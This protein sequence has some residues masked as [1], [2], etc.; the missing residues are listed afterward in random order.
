MR[1]NI[2]W[3][4]DLRLLYI[5][6]VFMYGLIVKFTI[7]NSLLF[8]V[9]TYIPEV[10]LLFIALL[11]AKCNGWKMR[12]C[13][14][15]LLTF[16][17]LIVT[18]NIA[19]HGLTEQGIYAIRDIYIPLTAFSCMMI[20][21][22]DNE[23][24]IYTKR[25]VKFF[26]VYLIAGLILAVAEQVKGWQ[27]TSVFY[28]G[29]TFYGQD[30]LSKIKVAHNFGLLRAPSL[31]GNFATFGYY[32][33]IAVITIIAYEKSP[34]RR[35]FWNVIAIAC[36]VL[37]TNKSA[38]VIYTIILVSRW[39]VDLRHQTIRKNNAT[40]LGI[41]CVLCI[42]ALCFWLFL[43]ETKGV[44]LS[45]YERVYYWVENLSEV[46]FAELILPYNQFAY[47]SGAEG[48]LS[49]WDNTYLYGLFTQG[50][51]G[52]ILWI[53][54]LKECYTLRT[55]NGD[56]SEREQIFELTAALAILSLTANVTQG[57]GFLTPYIVLIGTG[58]TSIKEEN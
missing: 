55:K 58:W 5:A 38:I 46:S 7:S 29:Y 54:A 26:K 20:P 37:A 36:M 53:N 13:F 27:W 3:S 34:R 56:L 17:M 22:T 51:V 31:S 6:Y 16:S 30:P 19:R 8:K 57:R 35:M 11:G 39:I 9:K 50:I 33:I 2:R 45:L 47:G 12:R 32:S 23:N 10:L 14:V 44:F 18:V 28:T 43:S 42:L 48:G 41:I 24:E 52:M 49:F 1:K 4:V 21:F 15:L 40:V 25:I